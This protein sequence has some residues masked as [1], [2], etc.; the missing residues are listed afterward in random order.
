MCFTVFIV[1]IIIFILPPYLHGSDK[2]PAKHT[3]PL[4]I[5]IFLAISRQFSSTSPLQNR[6][7]PLSETNT[8]P[9]REAAGDLLPDRYGSVK[10]KS[11]AACPPSQFYTSL[12]LCLCC[13][14]PSPTRRYNAWIHT[15][16]EAQG[17]V[18]P[19]GDR[20]PDPDKGSQLPKM[21]VVAISDNHLKCFSLV[22]QSKAALRPSRACSYHLFLGIV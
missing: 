9:H 22:C 5:L 1:I 6:G 7:E 14:G 10:A 18:S 20:P 17:S 13:A 2:Q 8:R 19:G 16:N 11:G 3:A 15:H 4:Q 12:I 21:I